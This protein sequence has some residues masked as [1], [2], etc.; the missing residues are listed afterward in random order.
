[1]AAF[2]HC[3]MVGSGPLE[4]REKA[5]ILPGRLTDA[6]ILVIDVD[7]GS[8][9]ALLH[10]LHGAGY[11][12]C[13]GETDLA[14][15]PARALSGNYALILLDI[16]RSGLSGLRF[17]RGYMDG[18]DGDRAPV[19]ILSNLADREIRLAALELGAHDFIIRPCDRVE[20]LHRVR[21]TLTTRLLLR[22]QLHLAERLDRE[23][24]VRTVELESRRHFLQGIMDSAGEGILVID[25]SGRLT[26]CN[27]AGTAMLGL[28]SDKAVGRRVGS[29]LP[30]L[31]THFTGSRETM[32][33]RA[34]GDGFPADITVTAAPDHG[35]IVIMRD[36]TERKV[37]EQS[38][39]RLANMDEVTRLPNRRVA[40]DRLAT[41]IYDGG[42]GHILFLRLSGLDRHADLFG[43]HSAERALFQVAERLGECTERVASVYAWDSQCF[44]LVGEIEPE[45]LFEGI[46]KALQGPFDDDERV[47]AMELTA[48]SARF[49]GDGLSATD[50]VRRARLA[51][52]CARAAE[53][54][55][56]PFTAAMES[57]RV[58]RHA[59]ED[60][61]RHALRDCGLDVY[62][63][64]KVSLLDNSVVGMEALV[65]MNS[66]TLGPVSPMEFIPICEES[67]AIVPVGLF[68]LRRACRD[69]VQWR[70]G[71]RVP[72][73]VA[74]NLSPRQLDTP[75]FADEALAILDDEGLPPQALELE[76][77]ETLLMQERQRVDE[78]L[79]RLRDAGVSIAIDDFGTGHSSLARLTRLR[80]DTLKIDRSFIK[81]LLRSRE[82]ESIARSIIDLARILDLKVVAE[83]V[84]TTAHAARLMDF[85]CHMGQGY[86]Y[87]PPLPR[88]GFQDWL[89][90]A[91]VHA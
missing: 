27:Q 40:L 2:T 7:P 77:T 30:E 85:R 69:T 41:C 38:F 48:G 53:T 86:L 54:G 73:T 56:L 57:A 78:E 80:A 20:I 50:L 29:F 4:E 8:A 51:E 22:E 64:P 35:S 33:R 71:G 5:P 90:A 17:L 26:E 59:V 84:E 28:E 34:D 79:L 47:L 19:I 25:R 18:R 62:Y 88:A 70:S 13:D 46:L 37:A 68:V 52:S 55:H 66:P 15:A 67:G 82:D 39:W 60:Q 36:A 87:A 14:K 63:Q 6:R 21:D 16:G 3:G 75:G 91:M 23:V 89:D 61:I 44:L 24:A 1:M 81:N 32:A 31:E 45:P 72:L 42:E 83:G 11:R 74:V 9:K 49:P 58:R 76:V 12:A 65:R 10:T 43:D